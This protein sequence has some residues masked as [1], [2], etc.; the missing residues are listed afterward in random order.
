MATQAERNE[1][2]L[3]AID[4]FSISAY[5][6]ES[7][8]Q[9]ADDRALAIERYL[10]KNIEP[11]PE[12]R[13]QIRDRSVFETVEWIKPSLLRIF[14]GSDE[15]AQFDPVGPEDEPLADQESQ[16]INYVITTKNPWHQIANDWFSDALLLKNGYAY[17]YWDKTVSTETEEYENL[18]DEGLA[19]MLQDKTVQVVAH[20]Q[21]PDEERA[22]Q[23][24]LQFNQQLQQ[25]QQVALQASLQAQQTG[26]PPQLPPPPQQPPQPMLHD[27]KIQ[28][29]NER[30]QVKICVLP[31]EHC[32]ID[33]NTPDYTLQDCN[34]F[35]WYQD[36][37][38]GQLRAAGFDIPDDITDDNDTFRDSPE[39]VARDLYNE[40]SSLF[41]N[42]GNY[43][44]P[45]SK[46][47]RVRYIWC[48]FDYNEDGINELQY[49]VVI[50]NNIIYRQD[51][52]EIPVA[53]ISPIPLAH[54][55]IGMSMADSVADIE[56]VN[57]AFTRQAI[58]NLFYSN[59]PRLA[60]SDRV[61]MSDLLDSRPGGIIRVDGQ[62]PQEVMPVVVP[63]M[64]PNAVNALQFFDSRRMNRTGINAYF[65]GTDANVL[66]KTASGIAQLTSSAAQRVEMIARLFAFGVERL[67]MITHRLYIQHGH[68]SEVVKLR[69]KWTQIDPSAWKRRMDVRITV[70]LGTG[71]KEGQIATLMQQFQAQMT[72]APMGIAQPVNIYRTLVDMAKASGA[73]N[74]QSYYTD[75]TTLPPQQPQPPIEL[76]I[77]RMRQQ[78][79]QQLKQLELQG[80]AQKQQ[81]EQHFNAWKAKFDAETKKWIEQLQ[82]ETELTK[83]EMTTGTQK[84]LELT[85]VVSDEQKTKATLDQ[86]AIFKQVD[87]QRE[88][89][90]KEEELSKKDELKEH[91]QEVQ[92]GLMEIV[93]QLDGKRV[94]G[95]QKVRDA[96]GR[97][98]AA[99]IKRGD[100]SVEDV[101][102][103]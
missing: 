93:K 45:S 88:A 61:N 9:L 7:S 39:D 19:M 89:A 65:Q 29:I 34:Y 90:D 60:V 21:R 3:A 80:N 12:G 38:I 18:T 75:P 4:A 55:H 87:L 92:Q 2:L 31:P 26:Q 53:S 10:G 32:L 72:V 98:V 71:N 74:P 44:D 56:D 68:A 40:S 20:S 13:S 49:V 46:R 30:G 16:Y 76:V 25:Y 95:V 66:N 27:L 96:N 54:R 99:R 5:N 14:C 15:V 42:D 100:G 64:F 67:F 23:L 35:E 33:I 48:R 81:A 41:D 47:V 62:P 22:A 6:A 77:E 63:D 70:G 78:G 50:G 97:M 11:A 84:E 85:K 17:A 52:E 83:T 57:T 24:Q 36:K 8:D 82:S 94:A 102:I 37:T 91:I 101:P 43:V 73:T 58:D 1:K 103:Q 51:C 79:A 28:R 69:N 59:N 86:N